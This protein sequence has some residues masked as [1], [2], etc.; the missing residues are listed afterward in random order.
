MIETSWKKEKYFQT[1]TKTMLVLANKKRTRL[2][3]RRS[4]AFLF[5]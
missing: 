1:N 2:I 5:W 3:H 4:S